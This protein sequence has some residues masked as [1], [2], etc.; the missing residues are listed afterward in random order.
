MGA[1]DVRS[2]LPLVSLALIFMLPRYAK[3]VI[4]DTRYCFRSALSVRDLVQESIT[5]H[6]LGTKRPP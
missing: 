4:S 5:A 3:G 1:R 2:L 6:M